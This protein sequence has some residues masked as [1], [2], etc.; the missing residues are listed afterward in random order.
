MSFLFVVLTVLLGIAIVYTIAFPYVYRHVYQNK[1]HQIYGRKI[2]RLAMR[3]DYYLIHQLT[4][5]SHDNSR[6]VVDHL[7]FGDKYIYVFYDFYC[8]ADLY[9]K[10]TD[11]S[12]LIKGKKNNSYTDNPVLLAKQ[13]MRELSVLTNL[14]E[15]L[16]I[17]IALVNDSCNI[18]NYDD[19]HTLVYAR[20]LRKAIEYYENQNVKPLNQEQMMYAV[21][22]LS[23]LN[24]RDQKQ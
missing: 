13:K 24:L 16:F 19:N 5:N 11:N 1:Y 22:D 18:I 7:M 10:S 2:Y 12:L 3:K 6:F 8:D 21:H 23:C 9:G 4:L 15:S 14:D 17:P 20:K